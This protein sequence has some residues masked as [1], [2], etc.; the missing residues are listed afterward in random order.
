MTSA[1]PVP[2][3]PQ[4]TVGIVTGASR[5]I[6]AA[7]ARAL[8]RAG[9]TVVL[10]ART[11]SELVAIAGQITEAGGRAFPLVTNVTDPASIERVVRDT[12]AVH[13][14]LDLAFNNAGQGHQPMRLADLSMEEF[15]RTLSVSA[16]GVFVSMKHE[17]AAMLENDRPGSVIVNMA[18]TAG[19]RGVPGIAGYVAAK[20]AIVGLTA[21]AALDYARDGIRVNAIAPGPIAS[22]RLTC[23]D[24]PTRER[25]ATG[26]PLGRLGTVEEV[27]DAVTWLCS[28]QASF[29]TGATLCVDGGKLAGGA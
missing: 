8:A 12:V 28:E 19:L 20:H 1:H 18:S 21:T 15:D 7:G 3:L 23:L 5:G 29:I 24:A 6:G 11:E 25:V 13:G 27:A 9:A 17:I 2:E 22:H 10:A 14:R 16:R 26:V 4:G